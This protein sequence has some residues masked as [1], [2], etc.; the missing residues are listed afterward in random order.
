M[1]KISLK[2]MFTED[3]NS[4]NKIPYF[5][6]KMQCSVIQAAGTV[7]FEDGLRMGVLSGGC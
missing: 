4:R 1:K 2:R 5:F 7:E 3:M 6:D